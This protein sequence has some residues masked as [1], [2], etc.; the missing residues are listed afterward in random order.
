MLRN[1][2]VRY[3]AALWGAWGLLFLL[4]TLPGIFGYVDAITEGRVVDGNLLDIPVMFL[5]ILFNVVLIV[6]SWGVYRRSA[7]ARTRLMVLLGIVYIRAIVTVALVEGATLPIPVLLKDAVLVA[8]L[9]SP[10]GASAVR[11]PTHADWAAHERRVGWGRRIGASW[12]NVGQ[13]DNTVLIP[14]IF[15]SFILAPFTYFAAGLF[16]VTVVLPLKPRLRG[17]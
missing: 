14:V 16:Y 4:W 3:A 12:Q 6:L 2:L 1:T 13:W 7:P 17:R 10:W 8:L 11:P 9:L 5:F 15:G